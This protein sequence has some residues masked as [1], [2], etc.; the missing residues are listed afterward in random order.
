MVSSEIPQ[1]EIP[2]IGHNSP[3]NLEMQAGLYISLFWLSWQFSLKGRKNPIKF[4]LAPQSR[5]ICW[6]HERLAGAAARPPAWSWLSPSLTSVRALS[7]GR[8]ERFLGRLI[9]NNENMEEKKREKVQ[10]TL[11]H[12]FYE[13]HNLNSLDHQTAQL[14]IKI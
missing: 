6:S 4:L 14:E 2:F 8:A 7:E 1:F 11:A 9:I 5:N 12:S 3:P 13:F 10:T